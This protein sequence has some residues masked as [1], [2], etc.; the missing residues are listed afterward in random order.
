MHCICYFVPGLYSDGAILH[1]LMCREI[2][3]QT[4]QWKAIALH[5]NIPPS[6]IE[7][8]S[9]ECGDNTQDCFSRVFD[10]W[11]K[12]AAPPFSWDTIIEVLQCQDVAEDSLAQQLLEKHCH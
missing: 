1:T 4:N 11:H 2:S 6:A 8:I 10:K 5:L 12:A 3:T 9:A 7:H